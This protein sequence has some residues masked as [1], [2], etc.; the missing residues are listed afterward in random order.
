[1]LSTTAEIILRL[2]NVLF[3]YTKLW[4]FSEKAT[5]RIL[6]STQSEKLKCKRARDQPVTRIMF[7]NKSTNMASTAL[8]KEVKCKGKVHPCTDTEALYRPY[9]P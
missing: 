8:N 1:V 6:K 7:I 3:K 5:I 4:C 9:G 2:R